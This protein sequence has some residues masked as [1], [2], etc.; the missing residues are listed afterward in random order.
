MAS[1]WQSSS[2]A[3]L[4][5]SALEPEARCCQLSRLYL[6]VIRAARPEEDVVRLGVNAYNDRDEAAQLRDSLLGRI[7]NVG[8][9]A[10]YDALYRLAVRADVR[11]YEM[12]WLHLLA[13]GVAESAAKR[14]AWTVGQFLEY[15]R[16]STAPLA[17]PQSLWQAVRLDVDEVVRN[18]CEG[19]FS[20]RNVL[21]QATE[22]DMQLWLAR[23][24][25]LLA[26]HRYLVIRE[27]ELAN[28]TTPDLTALSKLNHIVTLELKLGDDRSKPSL[29]SDLRRQLHDDYM[30]DKNSNFG[31]FV[32]M[33]RETTDLAAR[34][35]LHTKVER[36]S[37]A[38]RAEARRLCADSGGRKYLEV[39]CFICPTDVS[40]R[41]EEKAAKAAA[42]KAPRKEVARG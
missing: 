8:G 29:L 1:H 37:A 35:G 18:L 38:L 20:P 33:W 28:G 26:R 13:F 19:E 17:D 23:E 14:P 9:H 41:N 11:E 24:L 39:R 3:T 42:R 25:E 36:T 30:Q 6:L 15:S 12:R 16:Q 31:L 32:V 27:R 22:K 21:L 10:A 4:A 5:L 34:K 40:L 7:A 2:D